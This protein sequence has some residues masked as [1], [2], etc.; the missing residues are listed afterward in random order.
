[1]FDQLADTLSRHDVD[2]ETGIDLLVGP[3]S[4][5]QALG[6]RSGNLERLTTSLYALSCGQSTV[7][8]AVDVVDTIL[9]RFRRWWGDLTSCREDAFL[10]DEEVHMHSDYVAVCGRLLEGLQ[11]YRSSLL[12]GG[13]TS[14]GILMLSLEE[15]FDRLQV[16]KDHYA[17]LGY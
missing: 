10:N 16:L 17:T 5:R 3:A 7:A 11:G 6:C 14:A 13:S 4:V 12:A 2:D 9:A 15:G 8:E 1:M